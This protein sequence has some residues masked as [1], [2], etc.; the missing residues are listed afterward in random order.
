MFANFTTTWVAL[1]ALLI[2]FMPDLTI[3]G[4]SKLRSSDFTLAVLLLVSTYIFSPRQILNH[5][6]QFPLAKIMLVVLTW[7]ALC[8]VVSG[9]KWHTG[10]LYLMRRSSVFLFAYAG[11]LAATSPRRLAWV[12]LTFLLS[13]FVLSLSVLADIFQKWRISQYLMR[14]QLRADGLFFLG[15]EFASGL[16]LL[17]AISLWIA[18]WPVL[19]RRWLALLAIAPATLA[20]FCSGTKTLL[21]CLLFVFASVLRRGPGK[22]IPR[23]FILVF[24]GL[25]FVLTPGGLRER[26]LESFGEIRQ[27]AT[28][29][30]SDA[31][32]PSVKESSLSARVW[33]LQYCLRVLIP[34]SPLLGH[35]TGLPPLGFIDNFYF[36]ETVHHGL[37]GLGLFLYLLMRVHQILRASAAHESQWVAASARGLQWALATLMLAGL[38][39]DSFY[40]VRPMEAFWLLVGLHCGVQVQRTP[41]RPN[42]K[43]ISARLAILL[44]LTLLP[45][46]YGLHYG[47]RT[48]AR[49]VNDSGAEFEGAG[50]NPVRNRPIELSTL[51]T[52][53]YVADSGLKVIRLNLNWE[54]LQPE[55]GGPLDPKVV[56]QVKEYLQSLRPLGVQAILDIH[57]SARYVELLPTGKRETWVIG[58]ERLPISVFADFWA[59]MSREFREENLYAYGLMNEPNNIV[60]Q[61]WKDAS[62]AALEAI[63]KEGDGHHILVPGSNWSSTKLWVECHGHSPWIRDPL[64]NFAYE[65]HLY[66]DRD[67]GGSY[68]DSYFVEEMSGPD[69]E[70]RSRR[71]LQ[72]FVDWCL[73]NNVQGFIGEVGCP[74]DPGWCR[75]MEALL[76]ELD[77]VH[78]GATLWSLGDRW[79]KDYTLSLQPTGPERKHRPQMEV[80][81]RHRGGKT[82]TLKSDWLLGYEIVYRRL[83]HAVRAQQDALKRRPAAH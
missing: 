15:Q 13:S 10:F 46:F 76:G 9:E 41:S 57:N 60:T 30:V 68:K 33:N 50:G 35:G 49:G 2:A 73:G 43:A 29:L 34:Q 67:G 52:R 21:V 23:W 82:S 11:F 4:Q 37:I 59:K 71:W 79:P 54:S 32:A 64:N 40:L 3:L 24:L 26:L 45:G 25:A 48:V 56:A 31:A 55:L 78:M 16:V 12:V 42:R 47:Q 75:Q 14:E 58:S 61:V 18:L 1:M 63:R 5:L 8:L 66:F 83:R 72:P 74:S 65:A 38:A 28:S 62:Q 53:K 20:L 80:L 70:T 36:T 6:R 17:L 77:R 44:A 69:F 22:A 51:R 19:G 81:L 39:C 27:V 7:D